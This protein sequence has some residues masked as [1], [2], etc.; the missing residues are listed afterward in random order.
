MQSLHEIHAYQFNII[1]RIFILLYYLRFLF[2]FSKDLD[3]CLEKNDILNFV[4]NQSTVS[5]GQIENVSRFVAEKVREHL[6]GRQKLREIHHEP[7]VK[8][9]HRR[10]K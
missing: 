10:K 8:G 3:M 4:I 6:W 5:H 7:Q 2:Y 1:L 9:E